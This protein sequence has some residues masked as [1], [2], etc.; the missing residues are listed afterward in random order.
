MERVKDSK[1]LFTFRLH[2]GLYSRT[3]VLNQRKSAKHPASVIACRPPVLDNL[4]SHCYISKC[5]KEEISYQILIQQPN[6]NLLKFT[7]KSLDRG[8]YRQQLS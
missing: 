1:S 3:F 2:L 5:C 7:Y 8:K 4:L 6:E